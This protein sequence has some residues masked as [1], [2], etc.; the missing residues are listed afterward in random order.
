M[1]AKS[2]RR[3]GINV[4]ATRRSVH[5]H[6]FRNGGARAHPIMSILLNTSMAIEFR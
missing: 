5:R 6:G 4:G 3:N 2:S 1:G